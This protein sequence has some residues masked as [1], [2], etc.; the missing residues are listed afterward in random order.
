MNQSS[1]FT[2]NLL[3]AILDTPLPEYSEYKKSSIEIAINQ[4]K[5]LENKL[6]AA[7]LCQQRMMKSVIK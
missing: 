4:I 3:Q 1:I 2:I 6:E 5:H 7:E